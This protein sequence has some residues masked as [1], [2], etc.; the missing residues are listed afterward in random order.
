M[1]V[2]A[3]VVFCF[4]LLF[5]EEEGENQQRETSKGP[6]DEEKSA[7]YTPGEKKKKM[8]QKSVDSDEV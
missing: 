1:L 3:A 4:V 8:K 6:I 5:K 2:I 7:R